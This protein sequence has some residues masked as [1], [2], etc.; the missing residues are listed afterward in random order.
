MLDTCAMVRAMTKKRGPFRAFLKTY[1]FSVLLASL[2]IM[3][4]GSP[5]SGNIAKM[6]HVVGSQTAIA[7]FVLLLTLGA[8][9]ALWPAVRSRA[10]TIVVGGIVLALLYVSTVFDT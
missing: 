6:F 10:T 5:F 8:S 9:F 7:P 2:I 4:I 3:I 1:P